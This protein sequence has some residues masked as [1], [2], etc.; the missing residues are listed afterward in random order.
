MIYRLQAILSPADLFYCVGELARHCCQTRRLLHRRQ[1]LLLD[2]LLSYTEGNKNTTLRE[3]NTREN[4]HKC[5]A[6][7]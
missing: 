3:S 5:T 6:L 1:G 2:L 7:F 4:I